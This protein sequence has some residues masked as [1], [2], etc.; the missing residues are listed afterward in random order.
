MTAG[1][2]MG[3]AWAL[4]AGL[5][6]CAT[7]SP[8]MVV[9]VPVADLRAQPHTLARPDT[10]DAL[11]ETQLLYGEVVRVRRIERGWADVEAPEQSEFTHHQRWEGYPGWVEVSALR[12]VDPLLAPTVVVTEKWAAT[13]EDPF[14]MTPSPWRFPMGTRLRATPIGHL[15]WRVELLDGGIVWMP[16]GHA[17]ALRELARLPAAAAR[18]AVVRQAQLFL[19]DGY[20]WGGRSPQRGP[21]DG[22]A[23]GVD[24]SGLVNLAYR[25]AGMDVPRDAHEQFLRARPVAVPAPADLIFLSERGQP[26]R[27]VHV[28][29]YAGDEQLLEAPGT[30]LTVRRS[31]I[32]DRLGRPLSELT[33]G[34]VVDGQTVSFGAYLP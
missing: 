1:R 13:W 8:V 23:A 7:A 29:L 16:R 31:A 33:P 11:E 19:G 9:R 18:E 3:W 28:M 2:R 27:I 5:S 14:A 4:A 15:L 25:A 34:T 21:T 22:Q 10:H 24:C 17:R 6:G 20:Y 12:P 32:R 26:D 30:G